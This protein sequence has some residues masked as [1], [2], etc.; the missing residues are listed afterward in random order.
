MRTASGREERIHRM[1]ELLKTQRI[2][3]S[4]ALQEWLLSLETKYAVGAAPEKYHRLVN[5]SANAA[6]PYHQWFKYRE[7]F[8]GELIA[9]LIAL[10][11]AQKGELIIDPFCGSGTTNVVAV[12]SGYNTLGLDVNPMSAFLTNTK[13]DRYDTQ[14]FEEIRGFLAALRNFRGGA[15][16]KSDRE[17]CRYFQ[18]ARFDELVR[19]RSFLDT[20]PESRAGQLLRAAF[21]SIILNCSDRKRDGNGLKVSASRVKDTAAFFEEKAALMIEDIRRVRPCDGV[22][23]FGLCDTACHLYQRYE[24][25]RDGRRAGAIIFSPP[26]ANSFDY[27]ES[28]KLE[29]I[30]GGFADGMT[31]IADLRRGAVRSFV[32]AQVQKACDPYIDLIAKEIEE[33]IPAKEARTGK[34]DGRTRKVPDMIRGYFSDMR[35][36]LRQCALCLNPGGKTYIVVDQSAYLGKI[37]PTDLLL[38]YLGEQEGFAVGRIVKCR[39]ARTSTQQL[40]QYPYLKTTL[41]ESIV[42]LVRN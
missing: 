21:V 15:P 22:R 37:V 1:H 28:Y 25:C 31:G 35:E 34:K 2:Y 17:V 38:A 10:S 30:L 6:V 32:G 24:N 36:V 5:F 42:E 20:L 12:L 16:R 8:A 11:G 3:D 39:N 18:P 40:N 9:E 7:G 19:I 14:D 29:L 4:S 13:V 41:R 23:G 27:F 33:A 26:Y